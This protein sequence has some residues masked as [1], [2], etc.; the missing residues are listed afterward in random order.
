VKLSIQ[1]GVLSAINIGIS[2]FYQW[3]VLTQL[4]PGIETDAL[5]AGL[6]IPQLMLTVITGSLM[7]VLVPLL[8]GE[9]ALQVRRD[10]WG[11]LILVSIFFSFFTIVLFFSA[12]WWVPL[13]LPGFTE[14]GKALTI[15]LTRIQLIGVVFSAISSVQWAVYHAKQQFLWAEITPVFASITG[16]MFLVWALPVFGVVAAAWI[17]VLR[18]VLQ[19]IFLFPGMGH[20]LR[21][22]WNSSTIKEAWKR[23]KPLLLGTVYYKTEPLVDRFLL[24]WSGSGSLSLFFMAQRLYGAINQVCNKA[25][26]APLVPILGKHFKK[27][28]FIELRSVYQRKLLVMLALGLVG[29]LLLGVAGNQLLSLLLGYGH[30]STADISSLWWI[31]IWLGGTLIGGLAGHVTSSTFYACGDT[32]T[33]TKLSMVSYTIY[34]PLK[35]VAFYLWGIMGLAIVTSAYYLISLLLQLY[36]LEK[37]LTLWKFQTQ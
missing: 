3:Y 16:F 8:A 4:G 27:K 24:S 1:L 14:A 5:F 21:P 23:I 26:I 10:A 15:S 11:I 7:H 31:M 20:P 32:A 35:I 22:D 12:C 29:L 36:F 17:A 6:T 25:I 37:K 33:P 28:N 18:T 30:V 9:D 19:V 2:F 13:A 34:V